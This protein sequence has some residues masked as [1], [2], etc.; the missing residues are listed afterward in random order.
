[1]FCLS[2]WL[3]LHPFKLTASKMPSLFWRERN[4]N[5]H[6]VYP[7]MVSKKDIF[8][9]MDRYFWKAGPRFNCDHDK[10][11]KWNQSLITEINPQMYL[12][13][14]PAIFVIRPRTWAQ[15]R[16]VVATSD[17]TSKSN[18]EFS[19]WCLSSVSP[20]QPVSQSASQ[21]ASQPATR[22]T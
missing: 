22:R 20:S 7:S 11:T 21:P 16:R 15:K 19:P 8:R 10:C 4:P 2:C 14:N 13:Q 9:R 5:S 1:M 6:L 17:W 12:K 3:L 18:V